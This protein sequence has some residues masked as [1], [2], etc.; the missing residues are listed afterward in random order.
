MKWFGVVV[1]ALCALAPAG[2]K[3]R[4]TVSVELDIPAM[5]VD[6]AS[7]V[8]AYLVRGATCECTCTEC[9]VPCNDDNCTRMCDGFCT[10]EELRAGIRAQPPSAG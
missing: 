10:I 8:R 7:H 4:G 5:C 6:E 2:C 3:S 1:V 9:I